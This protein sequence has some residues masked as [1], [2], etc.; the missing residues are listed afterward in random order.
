MAEPQ[1]TMNFK[2]RAVVVTGAGRGLGREFALLLAARG[3]HVLVND[4]GGDVH[5]DAGNA[6]PADAVVGEITAAG[7]TAVANYD[8]VADAAGGRAIIAAAQQAFGRVADS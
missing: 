1:E 6:S 2:G 7:G 4:F 3:A 5:G 8:R